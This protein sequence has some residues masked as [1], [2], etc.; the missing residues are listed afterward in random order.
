MLSM[1]EETRDE[2]HQFIKNN[3]LTFNDVGYRPDSKIIMVQKN[4]D[5][6]QFQIGLDPKKHILKYVSKLNDPELWK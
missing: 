4:S 5:F 3:G 2:L 1:L 6:S